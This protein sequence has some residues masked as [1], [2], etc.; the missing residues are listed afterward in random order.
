MT[1]MT[2]TALEKEDFANFLT[3]I[4]KFDGQEDCNGCGDDGPNAASKAETT[5]TTPTLG[6]R[7]LVGRDQDAV[8][9]FIHHEVAICPI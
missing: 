5:P 2:T 9:P 6:R 1:T 7:L 4:V 8:H 3:V